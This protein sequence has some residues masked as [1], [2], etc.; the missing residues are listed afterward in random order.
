MY[1]ITENVIFSPAVIMLEGGNDLDL[2][3]LDAPPEE[4]QSERKRVE[5][6]SASAA[7]AQPKP[8]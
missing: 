8:R 1:V 2:T 7:S 4:P 5:S 3:I 6:E